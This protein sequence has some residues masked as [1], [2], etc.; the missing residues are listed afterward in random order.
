MAWWIAHIT[1]LRHGSLF[2]WLEEPKVAVGLV[3][4]A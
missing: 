3:I 2:Q 1:E 4:I